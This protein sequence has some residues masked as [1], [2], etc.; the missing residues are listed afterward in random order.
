MEP[1]IPYAQTA[2]AVSIAFWT[3]G[4]GMPLVQMPLMWLR[5]NGWALIASGQRRLGGMMP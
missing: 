2:D 4:E 1:R 3:I 5:Q